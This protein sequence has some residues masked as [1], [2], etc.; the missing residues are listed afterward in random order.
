MF[1]DGA[2]SVLAHTVTV[3]SVDHTFLSMAPKM[4]RRNH[5]SSEATLRRKNQKV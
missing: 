3:I 5:P 4:V 1:N 2:T